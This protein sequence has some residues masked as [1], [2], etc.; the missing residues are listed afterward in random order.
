MYYIHCCLILFNGFLCKCY[1]KFQCKILQ[2][3]TVGC[4]CPRPCSCPDEDSA[5][6]LDA[7]EVDDAEADGAEP[8]DAA[9]EEEV[10]KI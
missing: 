4:C 2:T 10:V 5:D 9:P 1:K 7:G 6:A 3:L 8:E